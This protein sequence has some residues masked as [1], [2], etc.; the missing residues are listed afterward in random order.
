MGGGWEGRNVGQT[1]ENIAMKGFMDFGVATLY[2]N[3]RN[4]NFIVTILPKL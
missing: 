1:A 3:T 2:I 4:L